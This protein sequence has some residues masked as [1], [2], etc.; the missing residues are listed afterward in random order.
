MLAG[1][2]PEFVVKEGEE[3]VLS[4][5]V[6]TPGGFGMWDNEIISWFVF[7]LWRISLTEMVQK[8]PACLR[9]QS[10]GS[11]QP[12][13]G[14]SDGQVVQPFSSILLNLFVLRL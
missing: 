9:L 3:V 2:I 13:G 14:F 5:P 12:T 11:L 7:S 1:E 4:C 8:H 10:N 6:N